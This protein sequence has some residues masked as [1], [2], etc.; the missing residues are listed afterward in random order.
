MS[1]KIDTK[2]FECALDVCYESLSSELSTCK[3]TQRSQK[4]TSC[5]MCFPDEDNDPFNILCD[6]CLHLLRYRQPTECDKRV[7][8]LQK[9]VDTI[10][11]LRALFERIVVSST[12][13]IDLDVSVVSEDGKKEV[14]DFVN[15]ILL[16]QSKIDK[17]DQIMMFAQCL[18]KTVQNHSVLKLKKTDLLL[19]DGKLLGFMWGFN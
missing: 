3:N 18:E 5:T 6:D 7:K 19:S 14:V 2:Q 15:E 4:R 11:I 17:I 9:I 1:I 16:P 13:E 12:S 8:K 10:G